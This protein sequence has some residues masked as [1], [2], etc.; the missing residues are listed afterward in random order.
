MTS[1][2][3]RQVGVGK[4]LSKGAVLTLFLRVRYKRLSSL[5]CHP[6]PLPQCLVLCSCFMGIY[7]TELDC[8]CNSSFYASPETSDTE[9]LLFVCFF[10]PSLG[11][12][13]DHD[14]C[15]EPFVSLS[16]GSLICPWSPQPLPNDLGIWVCQCWARP[17]DSWTEWTSKKT[18]THTPQSF[19]MTLAKSH[20]T[21]AHVGNS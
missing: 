5:W 10:F 9:G 13:G 6:A 12:G 15:P 11:G 2:R 21:L 3:G 4:Q 18:C 20:W 1:S 16:Y 7:W 17:P 14:S 19:C 8:W